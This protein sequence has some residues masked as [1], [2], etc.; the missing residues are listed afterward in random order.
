MLKDKQN[1]SN[2]QQSYTKKATS[3]YNEGIIDFSTLQEA[4]TE[5]R[6]AIFVLSS[7]HL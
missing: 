3:K 7:I 4:E 5:F 6:N 2:Y 1:W